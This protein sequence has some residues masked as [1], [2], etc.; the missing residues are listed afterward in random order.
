[1]NGTETVKP[2]T[3]VPESAR[4]LSRPRCRPRWSR[5]PFRRFAKV[6]IPAISGKFEPGVPT[7]RPISP[8][9]KHEI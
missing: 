6:T 8:L 7:G 2:T 1:M 5:R 4:P 9:F 3:S